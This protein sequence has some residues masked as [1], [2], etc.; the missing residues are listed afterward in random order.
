MIKQF[1]LK[2]HTDNLSMNNDKLCNNFKNLF[3][4][5]FNLSFTNKI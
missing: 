5:V 2:T 4:T 1:E 3:A